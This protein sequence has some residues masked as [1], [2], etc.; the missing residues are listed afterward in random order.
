MTTYSN[1]QKALKDIENQ[2]FVISDNEVHA[3]ETETEA[4]EDM[5]FAQRQDIKVTMYTREQAENQ[6]L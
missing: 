2:F 4:A 6:F 1:I 3:F 5:L